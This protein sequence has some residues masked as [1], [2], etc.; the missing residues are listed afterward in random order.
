MVQ[1]IIITHKEACACFIPVGLMGAISVFTGAIH[2][3]ENIKIAVTAQHNIISCLRH[4][5]NCFQICYKQLFSPYL[6]STQIITIGS[7]SNGES[8]TNQKLNYI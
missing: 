3:T 5:F 2:N 8:P 7:D 4:P 6:K 1:Q